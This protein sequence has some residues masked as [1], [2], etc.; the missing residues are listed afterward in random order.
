MDCTVSSQGSYAEVLI[1]EPQHII[2]FEN[3]QLKEVIKSSSLGLQ[4]SLDQHL[5]AVSRDL[6]GNYPLHK[7]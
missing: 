4:T 2:M 1:S 7:L 5:A 6:T 3:K